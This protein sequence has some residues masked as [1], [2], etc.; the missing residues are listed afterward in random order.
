M[1]A[2]SVRAVCFGSAAGSGRVDRQSVPVDGLSPETVA[3][4]TIGILLAAH[5]GADVA[6]AYRG[7]AQAA[8][9]DAAMRRHGIAN[10]RLVPE[11]S[12]V[13]A[14]LD[15]DERLDGLRTVVLYD[16]D[17][18]GL[19]VTVV[20]RESGE[21]VASEQ[22]VGRGVAAGSVENS[23]DLVGDLVEQAGV[24]AEAVVVLGA[25]ARAQD[26]A[27]ILRGRSA[28][29]VVV[30]ATPEYVAASGAALLAESTGS[31][32]PA[33]SPIQARPPARVSRVQ[34]VGAGIACAALLLLAVTGFGLGY[35][36][37]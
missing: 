26:A 27:G 22:S 11:A 13:P 5:A 34:L 15:L 1:G 23:V 14:W 18:T 2:E 17:E 33:A 4:E 12:A 28:I 31:A 3:V 30:A 10:V 19:T 29:P 35:G 37:A 20:D 24:A 36:R 25:G 6:V 32:P 16:L 9:L 21:V 7:E 8:A